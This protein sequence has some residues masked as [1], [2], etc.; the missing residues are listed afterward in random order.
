M[1]IMKR[2]PLKRK[3]P[4]RAKTPLKTSG[5]GKRPTQSS[6]Q[7]YT[8][9]RRTPLRRKSKS[10]TAETKEHIQALLRDI[11]ILRDGGCILRHIHIGI[12]PCNGYRKRDGQLILQGDHLITRA[13]SA[14]YADSRLVVCVCVGHHGWKKYHEEEYNA[15]VRSLL[16]KDRVELWDRCKE[17][18]IRGTTRKY[19]YDW[20]LEEAA[21][22]QELD[23]LRRSI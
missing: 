20:K 17:E 21:L 13:N 7:R 16:P 22:R 5:T 11:V 10:P 12:P 8:P 4:L 3:T 6:L 9:L 15:L 19:S 2:T 23:T 18:R 14:T 1:S